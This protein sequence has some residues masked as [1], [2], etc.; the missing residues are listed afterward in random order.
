MTDGL[1][2]RKSAVN[3][4][5]MWFRQPANDW[6]SAIPVGNGRL[7]AM[8]FGG[9]DTEHL[10][11]NDDSLWYGGARDRNNP[12]ALPNLPK[13]RE[14]I[15]AGRLKEAEEL[16]VMALSG[17]PETQRH[18]T[19]LG[20]L[21]IQ[22][23]GA[24]GEVN[25]YVRE[26][27]MLEG[28]ARVTF[29]KGSISFTRE[30]FASYP[31]Q[32][33]VIRLAANQAGALS[34]KCRMGRG[35]WRYTEKTKKL[36][37][38]TIEMEGSG[39]G[40]E[41]CQY[42]AVLRCISDG[43]RVST[44][45]EH[46][47]VEDAD[48]VTMLLVS[49]TTF[50]VS[51]PLAAC[52]ERLQT[53]TQLTIGELRE[54]HVHDYQKLFA[55]V[56][57]TLNGEDSD[58]DSLPTDERIEKVRQGEVDVAL[59]SLY[60]QFGRYL[61][62]SSS[63]PGSLPANLQG[64]WNPHFLPPWDS[65][66]TINI[67]TQMNY[68]L[69]ES[70]NLSE[71]HLPLFDLLERMREPGRQTAQMMY[72]CRGFAAHHNTD[73]WGDTAPQD[74]YLPATYW[75]MGAAWLCLHL[76]EHYQF[77][78][79]KEFLR[80]TYETMKE[81]AV[82]LLD[83]LVMEPG[84][85]RLVTCPSVSPENTYVLPS[86]ESGVLCYA[87]VMD[88]QII[89][90]LFGACQ[91]AGE[92]LGID[93]DWRSDLTE[94]L[95]RLPEIQVGRHGQIQEWIEDYEEL[96][97]GHRHISHLF[98]LYP[99]NQITPQHTPH[100]AKAARTTLERRLAHGGGHTGW[101]RA[102]IINFWARLGDSEAAYSNL[103]ELLRKSTLPNLFDNHPPFQIDGN[104]GGAAA[105]A[106]MLLQSHAGEVHLLPCLP[107]EWTHGRVTGLRARGQ[108]TV[109]IEWRDGKLEEAVIH[110]HVTGQ[111]RLRTKG[112]VRIFNGAFEVEFVQGTDSV[113][114]FA[115]ENGVSYTVVPS[116]R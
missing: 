48:A 68:W 16:A 29:R 42:A 58:E 90:A 66:F 81:A 73:I 30:V 47:I 65:K 113:L 13:I 89:R 36:D 72:G 116:D 88:S 69:A 11:L 95:A 15:F 26:L 34:F 60:F 37:A 49:D 78:G 112:T 52:L 75:P 56:S 40:E 79:D 55:R 25:D 27:N 51:N 4:H 54:R 94:A 32:A 39:G 2:T 20:D 45:G 83:Y 64:I 3:E 100:L 61:L 35:R 10:Q 7:G 86:G 77:T 50:R 70:C 33:I 44:I 91:E 63:R 8:I 5:R 92:I 76:W 105:I 74:T 101:S 31:D 9:V 104:F 98:A 108:Y 87:P 21:H 103:I 17:L 22:F 115:V 67:N 14:L 59:L 12:D 109:D 80:E 107:D 41:G 102:W 62:I 23:E 99:A 53:I 96:E 1:L 57:L 84:G 106:E 18:Y 28:I 82:F 111:S 6:N 71:C 114:E 93:G 43:G 46:L 97:P 24:E 38:C 85:E 19:P 110:S